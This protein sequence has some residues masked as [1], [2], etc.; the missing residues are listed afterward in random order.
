MSDL[1]VLIDGMGTNPSPASR[2]RTSPKRA[3]ARSEK[4]VQ[5]QQRKQVGLEAPH[6][7][8]HRLAVQLDGLP[9]SSVRQVSARCPL[10]SAAASV[11]KQDHFFRS[12]ALTCAMSFQC[13]AP[14]FANFADR[15]RSSLAV[16]GAPS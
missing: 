15:A 11:G 2:R 12:C 13:A 8:S 5:W 16:I 14:V 3:D 9:P 4:T 6:R 7:V 10:A 1:P